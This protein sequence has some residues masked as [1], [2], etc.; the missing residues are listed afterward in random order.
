[1]TRVSIGDMA[2]AFL[3]RRQGTDLK[4]A[5]NTL[6]GELSSGRKS[7][8]AAAV[9][10]DFRSLAGVEHSLS[11]LASYKTATDEAALLAT[12]LQKSLETVQTLASDLAPALTSA[13][14]TG[15]ATNVAT[16]AAD[17][18]QKLFTAVSALNV[19]VADRYVLSGAATDRKPILG[20]EDILT[21][22]S[23]AIAGQTTVSGIQAAVTAWFDAPP[24][25]GGY[26]D[27]IYGG[28]AAALPP[29]AIGEGDTAAISLTATDDTIRQTLK[30][31]SLG[32]LV[33]NGTL[34]GDPAGRAQLVRAAGDT[35]LSATTDIVTLRAN[36]GSVEQHV[37]TTATRNAAETTSLQITR[38]TIVAADPFE[39]ASELEA[40]KTQL[41]TLYTLTARLSRLSLTDFL[42]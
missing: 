30:G 1:M 36:L 20:A 27:V 39:T 40:V 4:T 42:R 24:G 28:S 21:A 25:G 9:S 32:A 17:A 33:A 31:L 10:G 6:T 26:R 8:L 23:G 34:A 7:D 22:L 3:L 5:L 37:A 11:T 41:E 16:S 35:L 29:F 2:Q 18:R 38:N 12:T 15:G 14:T 13:G 19:R